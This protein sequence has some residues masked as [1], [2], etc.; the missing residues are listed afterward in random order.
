[1]SFKKSILAAASLSL[2]TTANHAEVI[3]APFAS[4]F[5][6]PVYIGTPDGESEHL[7]VMEQ[8]GLISI[9]DQ[10]TGKKMDGHFLDLTKRTKINSNERGLLGLAFAPDFKKSGVFYIDLTNIKGDT[11]ILRIR[12]KKDNPLQADP[13]SAELLMTIK[14]D[15]GNHNGGWIGFGP[16][17]MLYIAMG[18]GGS[19]NDPHK[20]AQD[21]KSLLG[22]ILRLDVSGEKGYVVPK[23]N[24]F[25]NE[26]WIKGMRNPWRCSFDPKTKQFWMGDVGQNN[27]EEIDVIDFMDSKGA[28]FGW[29]LREATHETPDKKTG[30][31]APKG[32]IDP[33]Y[34]YQHKADSD[35]GGLSVTG[36]YV[37][38]GKIKELQGRYIFADYQLPRL[39]SFT[40]K[41]KKATDFK[42]M[43]D[44]L[45]K[46]NPP[47]KMISSFGT[48]HEQE[49]YV[50]DHATGTIHKFSEK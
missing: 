15:F 34:E 47:I 20:R 11:E 21:E 23:T 46:A 25:G 29:S 9:V 8:K 39:W 43:N 1:M 28:N 19:G 27:W 16:D 3:L 10:K 18:D 45:A 44:L 22:K 24:P 12:T 37:Y 7:W 13:E 30:G 4:G 17:K 41:G 2:L 38:R 49:L 36:G 33:V 6:R 35:K 5:D 40:L 50:V 32:A 42:V 48:D 31:S 26:V 14:Q